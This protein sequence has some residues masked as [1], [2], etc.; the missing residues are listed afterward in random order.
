MSEIISRE[1]ALEIAAEFAAEIA[2]S[3]P[4]KAVIAIGSLGGGYYRPGQSDIDT[5][6]ILDCTREEAS[7]YEQAIEKTAGQ[8]REKYGVPK[9]FGAV[10]M[11]YEQLFPPYV[12]EEELVLEIMR[13]KLQGQLIY[14]DLNSEEIPMPDIESAKACENAFENWRASG[15][16]VPPEQM[17]RQMTVNSILLL[18]RR[19]L[20]LERGIIEF[21]KRKMIPLYLA[22]QPPMVNPLYLKAVESYLSNDESV[23]DDSLLLEMSLWHKELLFFMNHRLLNR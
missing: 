12:P 22:H 15:F 11:G 13:I 6:I 10:I 7:F 18:I 23:I 1:R 21:D 16:H 8:Y 5:A 9:D 2:L 3:H 4:V 20:M 19:F 17:T 14:G